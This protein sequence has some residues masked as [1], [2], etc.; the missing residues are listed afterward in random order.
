MESFDLRIS[1]LREFFKIDWLKSEIKRINEE[2]VK[3]NFWDDKERAKKL[4][5]EVARYEETVSKFQEIE[6]EYEELKE[7]DKLGEDITDELTKFKAKIERLELESLFTSSYDKGNALLTIHP[8][9]GGTESCDWAHMLFR[10]YIRWCERK[11]FSY[12]VIDYEAGEVAGLKD[13]TIEIRGRNAYGWLKS[14]NGI[15]RLVRISPFDASHRRHTSFASCFVYPLIEKEVKIEIKETDLKIDTFRAS[16]PGGQY[17]NTA[18]TAV[19]I[20]HLPTGIVVT[21][22]AE[23]SQYQNKQTALKILKSRVYHL[24]KEEEEK[25]LHKLLPEKHEIGWAR[26]VRSY[27]F[28]PYTLVKDHRTGF[29]V[30]NIQ[31]VIDGGLD[32]FMKE[33][34]LKR[35]K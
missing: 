26:E 23:R 5:E 4:S 32:P 33:W 12:K 1:K 17:V 11:G 16:G 10:M 7:F 24:K 15:H 22:Q 25:K 34:L 2:M 13:A 14:E 28:H 6:N 21:C 27:I 29:E 19:R 35:K 31:E 30:H 20:T 3:P 9:A 8:G 18:S